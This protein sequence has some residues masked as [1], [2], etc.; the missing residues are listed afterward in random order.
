LQARF[1]DA[2]NDFDTVQRLAPGNPGS[3]CRR[4]YAAKRLG[5]VEAGAKDMAEAVRIDPN[6]AKGFSD[7]P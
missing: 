2:W 5:R 1:Q 6:V 4:G 7:L 3:L